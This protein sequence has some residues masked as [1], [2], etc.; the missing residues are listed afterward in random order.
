MNSALLDAAAAIAILF[1]AHRCEGSTVQLSV[2]MVVV[3]Q[4]LTPTN[5]AAALLLLL[6]VIRS[7]VRYG[8]QWLL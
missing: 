5:N 2:A 3:D 4:F 6:G 7:R 1:A 8:K